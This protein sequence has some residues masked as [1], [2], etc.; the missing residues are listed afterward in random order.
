MVAF[1]VKY[2]CCS[3]YSGWF[4]DA[5]SLK[6]WAFEFLPSKVTLVKW[7]TFQQTVLQSTEPWIVD[8]YAPWCGHCQVFAPEFE[9]VAQVSYLLMAPVFCLFRGST[10]VVI[11]ERDGFVRRLTI[12]QWTQNKITPF[13]YKLMTA[14]YTCV[15]LQ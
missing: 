13:R 7:A 3:T 8:F 9:R 12:A 5:Q 10:I 11:I 14:K 15:D 6:A 1:T 4:R 2:A